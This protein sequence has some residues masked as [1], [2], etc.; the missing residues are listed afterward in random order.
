M[1]EIVELTGRGLDKLDQRNGRD[2]VLGWDRNHKAV[3]EGSPGQD[4]VAALL[5]S[6]RRATSV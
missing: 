5:N 1:I 2:R 4:I 3:D 6:G